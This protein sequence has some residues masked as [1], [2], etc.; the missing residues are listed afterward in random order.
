MI[1]K[2]SLVHLLQSMVAVYDQAMFIFISCRRE[3]LEIGF[4]KHTHTYSKIGCKAIDVAYR[5]LQRWT[6]N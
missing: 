1:Y 3:E 4:S 6:A 2:T 5:M